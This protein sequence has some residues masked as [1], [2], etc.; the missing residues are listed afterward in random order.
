MHLKPFTLIFASCI[1]VSAN[2]QNNFIL[3]LTGSVA[4]TATS[5]I[6][7]VGAF[8]NPSLYA[9]KADTY[10]ALSFDNRF[11]IPELSTRSLSASYNVGYFQTGLSLSYYGYSLYNELITGL[12]FA[13]NFSE[14]FALGVQFNYYSAYFNT[15]NTYRGALFPQ[16]GFTIRLSQ[17]VHLAGNVFN[18]FQTAIRTEFNTKHLPSL[19]SLGI[20]YSFSENFVARVQT[21]KEIRSKYRFAGGFDYKIREIITVKTGIYYNSVLVSCLGFDLKIK[22]FNLSL[23]AEMHPLLGLH[24]GATVGYTLFKSKK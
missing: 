18:P 8:V 12:V 16:I 11:F 5:D 23:N 17:N 1:F 14:K 3:P 24:T 20:R 19:F 4:Q 13:R 6:D 7:N 21:D 9:Y 2:S 10:F 22:K 15:S